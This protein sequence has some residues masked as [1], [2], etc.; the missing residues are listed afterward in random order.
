MSGTARS[1]SH[2]TRRGS[3]CSRTPAP[4][5][6]TSPDPLLVSRLTALAERAHQSAGAGASDLTLEL[7]ARLE[8]C[9]AGASALWVRA[10]EMALERGEDATA[11]HRADKV[12]PT[13]LEPLW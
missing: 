4:M 7:A 12:D 9:P 8:T 6:S 10:A 3:P 13:V 1:C 11:R 2:T 5:A